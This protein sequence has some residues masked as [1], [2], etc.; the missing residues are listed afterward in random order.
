MS[1]ACDGEVVVLEER[2]RLVEQ[3]NV[4]WLGSRLSS[5]SNDRLV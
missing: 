1:N 4:A 2:Q 5:S 3:G